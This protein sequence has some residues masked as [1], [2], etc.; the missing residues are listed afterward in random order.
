[1]RWMILLSLLALP[2]GAEPWISYGSGGGIA[3]M[4]MSLTISSRGE[5]QY[6]EKRIP[7]RTGQLSE[8]EMQALQQAIPV[9]FPPSK[10]R[11][12]AIPDGINSG[13]QVGQ[14]KAEWGTGSPM[15]DGLGPLIE[16]LE[17][18]RTRFAD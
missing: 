1:M 3:G 10:R 13:L 2:A 15:P 8:S 12:P 11:K 14:D 9:P 17:K 16:Q 18:I 6:Q 7:L 5:V 4:Y